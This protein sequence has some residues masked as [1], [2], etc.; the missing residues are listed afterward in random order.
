MSLQTPGGG[1]GGVGGGGRV[2]GQT[3]VVPI[4][5]L[6]GHNLFP[7]PPRLRLSSGS[8]QGTPVDPQLGIQA[9]PIPSTAALRPLLREEVCPLP[10]CRGQGSKLGAFG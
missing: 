2:L 5:L 6:D 10:T 9:L 3:Q 1:G 7:P 4:T 8:L